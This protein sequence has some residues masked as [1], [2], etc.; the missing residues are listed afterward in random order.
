MF[1]YIEKQGFSASASLQPHTSNEV[2]H[3]AVQPS[4][5]D[6]EG[7]FVGIYMDSH[8]PIYQ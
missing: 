4:A 3:M 6:T 2:F 8:P 5:T 7:I 1:K